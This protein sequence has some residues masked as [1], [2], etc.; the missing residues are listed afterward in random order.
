MASSLKVLSELTGKEQNF[1]N[2]YGFGPR[3]LV[4]VDGRN[5]GDTYGF[6]ESFQSCCIASRAVEKKSWVLELESMFWTHL[7]AGFSQPSICSNIGFVFAINLHKAFIIRTASGFMVPTSLSHLSIRRHIRR[8]IIS[9]EPKSIQKQSGDNI[10]SQW[11]PV[12]NTKG[13]QIAS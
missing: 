1:S 7:E 13:G 10:T 12:S 9:S 8:H 2:N 4:R 3:G 6:L 5:K 11:R